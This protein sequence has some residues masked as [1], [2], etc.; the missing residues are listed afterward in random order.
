MMETIQ[1]LLVVV[2][3]V[4]SARFLYKKFF[5]SK[6]SSKDCGTDCGYH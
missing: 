1:V 3:S 2:A 5:P 6:A 4:I